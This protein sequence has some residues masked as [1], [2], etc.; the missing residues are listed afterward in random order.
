VLNT[1]PN[2]RPSQRRPARNSRFLIVLIVAGAVI[3]ALQYTDRALFL[4]DK[5]SLL[6]GMLT[7]LVLGG[8]LFGWLKLPR[9][10]G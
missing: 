4:P 1:D 10:G 8:F 6:W 7:G 2:D 9:L 5:T 3:V